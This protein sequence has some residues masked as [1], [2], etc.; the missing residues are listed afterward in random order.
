MRA[1]GD[2]L[3]Q[4]INTCYMQLLCAEMQKTR[5]T[6][7]CGIMAFVVAFFMCVTFGFV[8]CVCVCVSS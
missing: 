7:H 2:E 1:D 4:C 3:I 5:N 6:M 8:V